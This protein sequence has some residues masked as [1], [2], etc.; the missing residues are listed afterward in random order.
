MD[1]KKLRVVQLGP[2]PPP[3]GGVSANMIAI[4]EALEAS[5]HIST[6]IDVT[7]RKRESSN[8]SVLKPRSAVDLVK[9]LFQVNCDIVHYHIGGDFTP[10]LALLTLL[11][12]VLPRRRAVVTFHSGGY[13]LNA[14]GWSG[15]RSLRGVAFRSLD[16]AIGVNE[17]MLEMFRHFGVPSER[18]RLILPFRLKAPDPSVSIPQPIES[19]AAR[20]DPF[21]LSVGALES[22]Y[23]NEFLIDAMPEVVAESPNAGL[24]IVGSGSEAGELN[25]RL[26]RSPVGDRIMLTGNL[27]HATVLHLIERADML[28]R[29]TEYDG[30]SIAIREALFL[31]TPVIAT[32][33]VPRPE[34]VFLVKGPPDAA[35]LSRTIVQATET[36]SSVP[37]GTGIDGNNIDKVLDAYRELVER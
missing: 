31:G 35:G 29:M 26:E 7:N 30:D 24:M 10:K 4:H 12:G 6:I 11:C 25:C 3:H 15:P 16:L 5:G 36:A 9:L 22:A 18:S 28:L 27:D 34:G 19:F 23:R 13:A 8:A 17:R 33:S 14:K 21:L 1:R 37:V 2:M 20:F 32:D